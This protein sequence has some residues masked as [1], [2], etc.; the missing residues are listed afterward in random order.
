M[1][2]S[3]L[4]KNISKPSRILTLDEINNESINDII[5]LIYEIN[6]E[7]IGKKQVEPIKLIINSFGG[8]VY[9]GLALIDVIDN[10]TT[11]IYTICHGSAMSMA[12]IVYIAGHQRYASKNATFMY[13]EAA[14][15]ADGKIIHHK[16]ELKEVERIDKICDD[17]LLSK[18][19]FT[20]EQLSNI[21]KI[22]GEWYFDVET[23]LK[24]D[25]VNEI[26]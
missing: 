20:E 18:T 1:A 14:Y 15:P 6:D 12:L 9:S 17:Y 25:V 24:L 16:Q 23:A 10:S 8:E 5:Q 11:P 21:K 26:L 4:K 13:H 7:D 22:Q 19:L 3:S 2:I